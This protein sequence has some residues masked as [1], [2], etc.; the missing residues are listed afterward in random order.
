MQDEKL[1]IENKKGPDVN[2]KKNTNIYF[3]VAYSRYFSIS[4]Y[5]VINGLKNTFNLSW[6]RVRT[7]YHR[8]NNLAELLNGDLVE[9]IMR[10]IFS[11]DLMD[12]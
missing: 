5:R 9:K 12:R 7:S 8:F 6:I 10:G 11:K 4:I 3:C 1:E 2:K